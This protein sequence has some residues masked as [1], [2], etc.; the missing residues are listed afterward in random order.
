M[1]DAPTIR[2]L[3]DADVEA[4]IALWHAAGVA[5]PWNDPATDIAFARREPHSTVLVACCGDALVAT[6]MAGENRH[7][8]WVY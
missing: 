4:V 6:A 2:D 3:V 8:G 1:S 7:R 5:R